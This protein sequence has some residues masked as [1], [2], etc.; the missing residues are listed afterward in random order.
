MYTLAL[1][2][3]TVA[4][5]QTGG[6][7]LGRS[8]ARVYLLPL[9]QTDAPG[10]EAPPA[11]PRPRDP[12]LFWN[13][14]LLQTVKADRT[15]PPLAARNMAMVHVAV[16]D[17]VNAVHRSHCPYRVDAVPP[18]GTDARAAAATAG[19]DVLAALYP[20]HAR[21]LDAALDESLAAVPEG[22]G[23]DEGVALGRFV[24][25]RIV[26]WRKADGVTRQTA[27]APR[28]GRGLWRP[29]PPAFRAALLPQWPEVT[30]FAMR[31]GAQFR[32]AEP[33]ARSS[34]EYA[35]AFREVV[36]LG[37]RDS[38]ARTPEQTEI[39]HFWADGDGTVTPPGHWNRIAASVSQARGLTLPENARLFALL[40]VALA[41]AGI[42]AWDCKFHYD[43]WRPVQAIRETPVGG[44]LPADPRW[45]PLLPTPPFPSYTSGHSTF[46]AAAAAALARYFGTDDV[47]FTATSEGLPGVS[48][49]F[50][51]FWAAAAEAGQSRIYGGIHWQFDNVEGLDC[52]RK[53]GRSVVENF[54]RPRAPCPEVELTS[55]P[56]RRHF[57]P[58]TATRRPRRSPSHS[59][60]VQVRS[61]RFFQ[62]R[63]FANVSS[64][65]LN[66]EKM[67]RDATRIIFRFARLTATVSRRGSSRNSLHVNRYPRSLSVALTRITVRSP[68]WKR[69][70]VS[71]ADRAGS[72]V[73][74]S[75]MH[76]SGND[77]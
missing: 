65:G 22:A 35:A 24:A 4:P 39:A 26:C 67:L 38:K 16:Y 72:P 42:A 46:S 2:A 57:P 64:S 9:T 55:R 73:V 76:N 11:P 53:V 41:D 37:G 33:P 70:T 15:P 74:A 3:A 43:F 60:S 61:S 20:R 6:E 66:S 10:T 48:R 63:A 49:S 13:D 23:R 56:V 21:R 40:N 45:Q 59:R 17:A 14:V 19:H 28:E 29:T 71:M 58:H 77:C 34:V 30:C 25:E 7:P 31:T 44:F 68:P 62:I 75:S 69:S 51:G 32:P 36:S 5:S 47:R 1:L 27:Y 12:V 50:P 54:L 52:G 18:P 8:G